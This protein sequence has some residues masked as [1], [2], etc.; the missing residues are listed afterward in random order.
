MKTQDKSYVSSSASLIISG[1]DL[2]FEEIT[3]ALTIP[4]TKTYKKGEKINRTLGASEV[5]HWIYQPEI[6]KNRPLEEHIE[7]IKTKLITQIEQLSQIANRWKVEIRCSYHSDLAQGSFRLKPEIT[8]F[9]G[10]AG[11]PFEISILSWGKVED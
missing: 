8:N 10:H 3:K 4:P 7:A 9:F 2:N 6:D 5:A 11:I 1:A